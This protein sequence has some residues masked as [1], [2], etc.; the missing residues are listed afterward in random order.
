VY[1]SEHVRP[2]L[3]DKRTYAGP[4]GL[5][6]KLELLAGARCLLI[7]SLVAETSSLVAMEAISSGIPVVA[8]RSGALPEV[9]THEVTGFI[10]DSQDEMREAVMHVAEISPDVC[11]ETAKARFNASRM[12]DDYVR[13]Y[14]AL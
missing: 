3:D 8:F 13:L 14:A 7:P 2:L 12:V 11:H 1:F 4:V 10:V 6:Q 5:E 9:V